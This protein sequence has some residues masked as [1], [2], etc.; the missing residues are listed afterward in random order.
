M[1]T[2]R[3][4]VRITPVQEPA[5]FLSV[6]SILGIREF[7]FFP[8]KKFSIEPAKVVSPA[9][10]PAAII[11]WGLRVRRRRGSAG[12][13]SPL[14]WAADQNSWWII[15]RS[16]DG[17]PLDSPDR[18]HGNSAHHFMTKQEVNKPRN[19]DLKTNLRGGFR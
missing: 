9:S 4:S 17:H 18:S 1:P 14:A 7:Q 16:R 3:W 6:R 2:W 5:N 15:N 19:Q 11:M 10:P 8:K 12:G 13:L